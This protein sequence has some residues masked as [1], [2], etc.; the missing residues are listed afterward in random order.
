MTDQTA[1]KVKKLDKFAA[2][3]LRL[4]FSIALLDFILWYFDVVDFPWYMWL[5]LWV[6]QSFGWFPTVYLHVCGIGAC[7]RIVRD[8]IRQVDDALKAIIQSQ[9]IKTVVSKSPNN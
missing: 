1:A 9:K 8:Q 3:I 2:S 4:P 6:T 5:L 7:T